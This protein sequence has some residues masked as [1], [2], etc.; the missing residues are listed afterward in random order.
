MFRKYAAKS[1]FYGEYGVGKSTLW[2]L[3]HSKAKIKCVDSSEHWINKTRQQMN[4]SDRAEIRWIDLGSLEAWG[5]PADYSKRANFIE[6]AKVIWDDPS[7][8]PDL[9]FIDGRFRVSCFLFS[10]MSAAPGTRIIFDDYIH[11]PYY[12]VVE[13]FLKPIEICGPQALFIVPEKLNRE[14]V[15]ELFEKFIYVPD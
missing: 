6:Y 11:R 4:Y 13:E 2:V 14:K 3:F 12:H 15:A 7:F 5:R 1:L 10:V 9:V 8:N